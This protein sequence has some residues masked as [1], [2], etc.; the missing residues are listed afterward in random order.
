MAVGVRDS[1]QDCEAE[2]GS[3]RAAAVLGVLSM[4]GAVCAEVD[5]EEGAVQSESSILAVGRRADGAPE[6][7][8]EMQGGEEGVG[9]PV[10]DAE[11]AS[12]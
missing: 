2:V 5:V 12:R 8:L 4:R 3:V 10:A 7:A 1:G 9:G 6:V 11:G